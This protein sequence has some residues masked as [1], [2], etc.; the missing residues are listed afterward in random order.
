M[1][2]VKYGE[3]CAM[4][5]QC[6]SESLNHSD[7]N[8]RNYK[9]ELF[10]S[11]VSC[12]VA[13]KRVIIGE[14]V[15]RNSPIILL[16]IGGCLSVWCQRAVA[17]FG[18]LIVSEEEATAADANGIS[19][20][21]TLFRFGLGADNGDFEG[22]FEFGRRE[23]NWD[24][25]PDGFAEP[26]AFPNDY[27]KN[28]VNR[29]VVLATA[30]GG[31]FSVSARSTSGTEVEFGNINPNFIDCFEPLSGDRVYSQKGTTFTDMKFFVPGTDIPAG[32]HSFGVVFSD[33][34]EA[35]STSVQFYDANS[36]LLLEKSVPATAGDGSF[37][38]V[39]VTFSLPIVG[40][41]RIIN[42]DAPIASDVDD[43]TDDPISGIDIVAVDDMIFSEP[44]EFPEEFN[45]PDGEVG[46]TPNRL[47][48]DN[49]YIPG[50]QVARP[51]PR[52]KA[53]RGRVFF[54]AENDG[55][56]IDETTL[57]TIGRPRAL[58]MVFRD[59]SRSGANITA[60]LKMSYT[61]GD[62]PGDSVLI[63]SKFKAKKKFRL[64]RSKTRTGI[65]A[66]SAEDDTF[67]LVLTLIKCRP[68]R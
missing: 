10:L 53:C 58:K 56:T 18:D 55:V 47:Q 57:R 43:I 60:N 49:I 21:V 41:V 24:D 12:L 6:D 59:L 44:V 16:V 17:D 4:R 19:G 67:D 35:D 32:I 20:V 48:G 29:G 11:N 37:S 28:S 23:I 38:F 26:N 14:M 8:S 9:G 30:N 63:L 51:K 50:A 54:A 46:V 33:V 25:V 34:D 40:T 5:N 62:C 27:Y 36:T 2:C 61:Y 1:E 64:R 39:G 66:E 3:V 13:S 45:R 42:G 65:V 22:P 68:P 15:L 31:A 52:G 7:K